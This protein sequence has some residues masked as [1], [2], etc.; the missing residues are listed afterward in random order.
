MADVELL[1]M[2]CW[3]ASS[4]TRRRKSNS[5]A[6]EQQD[7]IMT[8]RL[9]DAGWGKELDDALYAEHSSLLIVCPFIKKRAAKRLLKHG[10]P[11]TVKVITRFNLCDFFDGVSDIEALR[12]LLENGA[13]IRGIRHLHAKLYM[14][15]CRVI[16]TS[17]NLTDAALLHNHEFGFIAEDA[18]IFDRCHQYFEDLWNRAGN[19]LTVGQVENWDQRIRGHLACGARPATL[20]GLGDEGVDAGVPAEPIVLPTRIIDAGQAFVKFFGESHNRADR[21]FPVIDEVCRSGCHRACTY[22]KGKRPRQVKDGAVMFMGRLVNKPNDIL[23]YGRAVGVHHEPGRDDATAADVALRPW[24]SK[25]PHYIRVHHP[26]FI[27]GN[28]SNGISLNELMM[29]L[30]SDAFV[31]TQQNAERGTGNTEPRTA[32]R[33]QAA[34][35]LASLGIAWLNERLELAFARHG[36][37]TPIDMEQL[38]WPKVPSIDCEA[39]DEQA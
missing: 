17:A 28:L 37:L 24:K 15:G 2:H 10:I 36:K 21:A 9:V 23:I 39:V 33:Q 35:E 20:T 19:N 4:G 12:L 29:N 1:E 25:W 22:P 6:F 27:A 5:W 13:Q 31:S 7:Q 8:F 38:D 26:E 14:F 18:G 34:V 30:R 3:Q 16:V 32:Y 11:T